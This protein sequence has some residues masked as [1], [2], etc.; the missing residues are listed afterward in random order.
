M[1]LK[2]LRELPSRPVRVDSVPDLDRV[3][4]KID[5]LTDTLRRPTFSAAADVQDARKI[6]AHKLA[7]WLKARFKTGRAAVDVETVRA[8]DKALSAYVDYRVQ[9]APLFPLI[10]LWRLAILDEKAAMLMAQTRGADGSCIDRLIALAAGSLTDRSTDGGPSDAP[11]PAAERALWLTSLRLLTNALALPAAW[12]PPLLRVPTALSTDDNMEQGAVVAGMLGDALLDAESG[13]R[14]V[15]AATAFNAALALS[16]A[17]VDWQRRVRDGSIHTPSAALA[18]YETQL[19]SA[20]LEALKNDELSESTSTCLEVFALTPAYRIAAALLH[21][22]YRSPCWPEHLQPLMEV[23]DAREV[24]A[25]A[26]NRS[27][28]CGKE[29]SALLSDCTALIEAS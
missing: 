26:Q 18:E 3:L 1:R 7:P 27:S 25:H 19:A 21:L 17:R 14:A 8:W 29:L 12:N 5:E 2:A 16:S 4:G 22:L 23:L 9:V 20:L 10:D 15:A 24:L 11:T 13:V 28:A 6:V